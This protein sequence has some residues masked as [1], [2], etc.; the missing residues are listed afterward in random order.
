MEILPLVAS[1]ERAPAAVEGEL[2]AQGEGDRRSARRR[3]LW[4]DPVRLLIL[5]EG[6]ALAAWAARVEPAAQG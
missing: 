4:V 5:I 1:P 6:P 3:G 2:A